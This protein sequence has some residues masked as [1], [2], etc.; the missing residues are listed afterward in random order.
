MAVR[1]GSAEGITIL[2]AW[3]NLHTK[4]PDAAQQREVEKSLDTFRLGLAGLIT[5]ATAAAVGVGSALTEM[6]QSLAKVYYEAGRI[7]STTER[8]K[9]FGQAVEQAGGSGPAAIADLEKFSE[10][11][12]VNPAFREAIKNLGHLSVEDMK[13]AQSAYVGLSKV[14]AIQRQADPLTYGRSQ[15]FA[16]IDEG[17]VM[18]IGRPI[19]G[20]ANTDAL[21]FDKGLDDI[22]EKSV[23]LNQDWL[24]VEQHLGTIFTLA[25]GKWMDIESGMLEK[26]DKFLDDHKELFQ[27]LSDSIASI[28]FNDKGKGDDTAFGKRV[29]NTFWS[30]IQSIDFTKLK[31]AFVNF[32]NWLTTGW[33]ADKLKSAFGSLGGAVRSVG[34]AVEGALGIQKAESAPIAEGDKSRRVDLGNGTTSIL[35]PD[36]ARAVVDNDKLGMPQ[37]GT[38][39]YVKKGGYGPFSREQTQGAG[40]DFNIPGAGSEHPLAEARRLGGPGRTKQQREFDEFIKEKMEGKGKPWASRHQPDEF[41]TH[42]DIHYD[43]DQNMPAIRDDPARTMREKLQY[44]KMQLYIDQLRA[45]KYLSSL[46]NARPLE[47]GSSQW[48]H[49]HDGAKTQDIRV[50]INSTDPHSAATETARQLAHLQNNTMRDWRRVG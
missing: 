15:K 31:N 9:A 50:T 28:F 19:F 5:V 13:D 21:D 26:F 16:G 43:Q 37:P 36:G 2:E 45:H 34:E 23:R 49:H 14:L 47:S 41:I 17:T 10:K 46:T 42:P 6:S 3:I 12:R 39:D 8:V 40:Q 18:A 1:A 25:S 7:G 20:E 24:K 27:T 35:K 11:F 48:N 4:G 32:A 44:N 38:Q 30:W 22:A 29:Y 33:L